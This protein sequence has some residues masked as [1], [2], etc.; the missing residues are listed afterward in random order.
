M[1]QSGTEFS[2]PMVLVPEGLYSCCSRTEG[3]QESGP[4]FCRTTMANSATSSAV[5]IFPAYSLSTDE[6][7]FFQ[8]RDERIRIDRLFDV[9]GTT[10]L[11][12]LYT[13]SDHGIG[14][15]GNDGYIG[16]C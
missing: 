6:K 12:A 15:D 14:G 11:D 16:K 13:I 9:A 10:S 2:V 5:T 7:I 1:T 8:F 3:P 4:L